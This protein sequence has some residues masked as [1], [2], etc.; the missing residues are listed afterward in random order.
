MMVY[1]DVYSVFQMAIE[2]AFHKPMRDDRPSLFPQIMAWGFQ[3]SPPFKTDV[4][5]EDVD[6]WSSDEE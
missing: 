3:E 1:P 5:G 6:S 2:G 4:V